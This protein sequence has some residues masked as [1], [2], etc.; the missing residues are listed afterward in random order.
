MNWHP[1]ASDAPFSW[2]PPSSD[3]DRIQVVDVSAA[4]LFR[5]PSTSTT[6]PIRRGRRRR[7]A[8]SSTAMDTTTRD[9]WL[10]LACGVLVGA[11]LPGFDRG[12]PF[13]LALQASTPP[14][15]ALDTQ[16]APDLPATRPSLGGD[17]AATP[18]VAS[19][20]GR[21]L[22]TADLPT[23]SERPP[24][25][26]RKSRRSSSPGFSR[27]T[28]RAAKT[29]SL[30]DA[31][32]TPVRRVLA[33]YEQA[34]TRMDAGATR[35]I[36]PSAGASTLQAAFSPVIEQRLQ[37]AGCDVGMSGDRA[38]AICMGTLTY[39]SRNGGRAA[40]VER[41]RWEFDLHRTADGWRI[42]DVDR[43]RRPMP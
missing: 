7:R 5:D 43:A 35:A 17:V 1:S 16:P 20:L 9:A 25:R 13:A 41:G 26:A 23:T 34:W 3:V 28:G 27:A 11:L 18:A 2:P 15:P 6:P 39:R 10:L 30:P 40:R 33:A 32:E 21:A 31:R 19:A 42:G 24:T 8:R 22:P 4:Q 29:E 12:R 37:L 14:T 38:L 36:W